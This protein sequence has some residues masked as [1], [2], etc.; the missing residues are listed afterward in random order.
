M[1]CNTSVTMQLARGVL[2]VACITGAIVWTPHFWPS[3]GLLAVAVYLMRGCP[4]CWLTGLMDAIEKRSE[5]Q[6]PSTGHDTL[7][8]AA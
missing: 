2:A 8:P 6:Q 5:R 3:I 4:A 7:P 1:Y